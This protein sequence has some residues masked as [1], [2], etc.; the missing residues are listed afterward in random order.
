MDLNEELDDLKLDKE[1]GKINELIKL[2][3]TNLIKD[4]IEE[5]YPIH[6]LKNNTKP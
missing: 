2:D 1:I 6:E 4:C 3:T 5:F